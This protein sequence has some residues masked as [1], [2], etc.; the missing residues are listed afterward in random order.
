MSKWLSE[1]VSERAEERVAYRGA[2][3]PSD[4]SLS[5]TVRNGRA[6]QGVRAVRASHA[7]SFIT[8]HLHR[9]HLLYN[10]VLFIFRCESTLPYYNVYF[11]MGDQHISATDLFPNSILFPSHNWFRYIW[12]SHLQP[13]STSPIFNSKTI[14][15]IILHCCLFLD[16]KLHLNV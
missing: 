11:Q 7:G 13:S 14:C 12:R 15:Y 5:S 4:S 3:D 6:H 8:N 9:K 2:A 16:M 1:S 10:L